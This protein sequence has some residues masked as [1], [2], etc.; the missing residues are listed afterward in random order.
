MVVIYVF[1]PRDRVDVNFAVPGLVRLQMW[2][3]RE[4]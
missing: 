4:H 3:E 1:Q 2:Y